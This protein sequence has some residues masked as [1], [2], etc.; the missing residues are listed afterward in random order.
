MTAKGRQRGETE[1][2]RL[3]SR[4]WLHAYEED[5]TTETVFRPA[6]YK[7]PPSRGR[8]GFELKTGGVLVDISIGPADRPQETPGTWRV[9]GDDTLVFFIGGASEPSRVLNILS[10]DSRRLVLHRPT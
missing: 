4:R 2:L 9:E 10:V 3:L 8:R 6:T 7:F 1:R 5:T